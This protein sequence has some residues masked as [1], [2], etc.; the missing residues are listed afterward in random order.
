M[1][2]LLYQFEI[3]IKNQYL[4]HM[5]TLCNLKTIALIAF[6]LPCLVSS[7]ADEPI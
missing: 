7:F 2:A 4:N 3:S 1:K 5:T 6:L